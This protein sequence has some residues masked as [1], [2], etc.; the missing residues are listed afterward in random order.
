MP[1]GTRSVMTV[2][3]A[4]RTTRT[5]HQGTL[6]HDVYTGLFNVEQATSCRSILGLAHATL[7]PNIERART[8]SPPKPP[9]TLV[10]TAITRGGSR[11]S[12]QIA[13]P[14]VQVPVH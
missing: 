13:L 1:E 8:T 12:P 10:T 7:L 9:I 2:V 3:A 11:T 4:E 5:S 6:P 14:A